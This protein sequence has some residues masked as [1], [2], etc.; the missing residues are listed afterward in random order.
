MFKLIL[1]LGIQIVSRISIAKKFSLIFVLY[2]VPVGYVAYYAVTNHL[3]NIRATEQELSKLS[4]IRAFKPVFSEIA[5]SRGLTNAYLNGNSKVENKI[6]SEVDLVNQQFKVISQHEA[7][8]NLSSEDKT[9]Y[10]NLTKKWDKLQS[11]AK[12]LTSSESFSQHSE[13]IN[14]V[15]LLMHSI[16]ESSSLFTDP[17]HQTSFLIKMVVEDLPAI[18]EII[19]KTRGIG[20]GVA[21]KGKFDSDTYVALSNYNKQLERKTFLM[22]HNFQKATNYGPGLSD[23]SRKFEEVEKLIQ[24]FIE[25][26]SN[27]ILDPDDINIESDHYFNLGSEAISGVLV[28]YGDIYQITYQKL[29]Q[30]QSD[31]KDEIIL[32]ISS[33]VLL[34]LAAIYLFASVY[35]NMLDSIRRIENGVN[36]VADGDLTVKVQVNSDDEMNHIAND[37]NIMVENTKALVQEVLTSTENLVDTAAENSASASATDSQIQQQ[38]IEVEQV[39]TA[40]NEMSAT[41]QEVANNAEQTASSSSQADQESKAGFQI[42]EKTVESI[43]EL[44]SE[45]TNASIS[46]NELQTDVKSISSVLDVIQGIADQTN[47]LALNAAIEAARAGE[48]GRGFAVVADEVRTLASKTQESTEEI[49]QMID[50]L[51]SSAKISVTAMESG[52]VKSELTVKNAT[53]AGEALKKISDSVAHISLMGEQIAS[54]A[55]EQ[56]T[57]AEEINRSVIRVKDISEDTGKAAKQSAQN[58]NRLNDVATNLKNLVSKFSL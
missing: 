40:M 21:A 13:L 19:G 44:A 4:L 32:N 14:Q 35:S 36:A 23:I 30:R 15:S 3:V 42:V 55:T 5:A 24:Q 41:V 6:N 17:E 46:I 51:Q 8:N 18:S 45:L 33:S 58:S 26:T 57:V 37:I 1:S 39:A 16:H 20:A 7:F 28:L 49:R 50:K 27:N 53:D 2:L 54:A 31:I 11:Q 34:I 29:Q 9:N 25:T 47:L 38:N 12:K 56:S 43:Q 22:A 48:S 52:N 10:Q